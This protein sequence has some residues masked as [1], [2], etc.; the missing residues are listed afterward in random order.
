M[1][2]TFRKRTFCYCLAQNAANAAIGKQRQ[3]IQAESTN[4]TPTDDEFRIAAAK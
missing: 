1:K 4:Y 2:Q 3:N